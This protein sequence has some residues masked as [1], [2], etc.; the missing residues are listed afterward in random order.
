[1]PCLL[2]T[3]VQLHNWCWWPERWG[4]WGTIHLKPVGEVQNSELHRNKPSHRKNVHN[5]KNPTHFGY[6]TMLLRANCLKATDVFLWLSELLYTNWPCYAM[7][8]FSIP[9]GPVDVIISGPQTLTP[10]QTQRFLCS[11]TCKPSCSYT[12]VIDGDS[13][14]GPGDEVV[15]TAPLDATSGTIMCKATNSVSRLFVTAIRKL[16]ATGEWWRIYSWN[17]TRYLDSNH[18]STLSPINWW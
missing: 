9:E 15:I 10:G 14:S 2:L 12:W 13:V 17:M 18:V 1:M 16:N 8:W 6:V 5:Q 7:C 4:Q 11:A 3:S